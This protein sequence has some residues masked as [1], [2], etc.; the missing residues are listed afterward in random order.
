MTSRMTEIADILAQWR[1]E[2]QPRVSIFRA[3]PKRRHEALAVLLTG[4]STAAESAVDGFLNF[5]SQNQLDLDDIWVAQCEGRWVAA[6]LMVPCA[7]R[8]VMVFLSPLTK[9]QSVPI[10]AQ[11]LQ[12]ASQSL[13]PGE[14]TI[15]QALLDPGQDLAAQALVQAGFTRLADLL[16]LNCVLRQPPPPPVWPAELTMTTWHQG[17]TE[18]FEQTI[19]ES[20]HETRDYPGLLGLRQIPDIIQ[21]HMKTGRFNP[22]CWFAW[23]HDGRPVG[24]MLLNDLPQRHA[25][26][27]VYL[28]L[29][30]GWRRRGL[31]RQMMHHG[32]DVTWNQGTRAMV[33]AVDQSN[34][35]AVT[36]Y[37]S[38]QF[39]AT[40]RKVA[41]IRARD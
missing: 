20:Y 25:M 21:G 12:T 1:D 38:L 22:D 8:T 5:A 6:T 15:I 30:P 11:L 16:Y 39:V 40:G 7:G 17:P 35:P 36:L 37:R 24:V 31:G 2:P 18:L 33:C 14:T 13:P 41:F 29:V 19:A 34:T 32:L 4:Q 3:G 26:E 10:V 23:H 9:R 27:L 28:G